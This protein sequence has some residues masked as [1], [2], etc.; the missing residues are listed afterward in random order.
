MTISAILT[1]DRVLSGVTFTSKKKALEALSKLL[2][3]DHES[4]M[5]ADVLTALTGREKLGS[6]GL[7]R[8]VAVP[9]GRLAGIDSTVGALMRLKHPLDYDAPDGTRVDLLFGLIVPR[10]TD[11][12]HLKHLASIT[13]MFAD[14]AFCATL[15]DTEDA[16]ALHALVV[17]YAA[18]R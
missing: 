4:L 7:G 12:A 9:H 14:E 1:A 17:Q 11:E 6:T 2:I 8:G 10:S 15:R 3:Q 5:P 16:A 13:E 18:P